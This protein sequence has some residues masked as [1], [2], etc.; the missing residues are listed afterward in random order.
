MAGCPLRLLTRPVSAAG[1][2]LHGC[3][4]F[5]AGGT[6]GPATRVPVLG[7]EAVF[8]P[9]PL[10]V[11]VFAQGTAVAPFYGTS[12]AAATMEKVGWVSRSQF[13]AIHFMLPYDLQATL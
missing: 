3:S 11:P 5:T 13:Q 2:W 8:A 6:C 1:C 7:A 12:L 10:Q 4:S 9:P